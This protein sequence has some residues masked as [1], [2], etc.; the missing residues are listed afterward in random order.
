MMVENCELENYTLELDAL[1]NRQLSIY[2]YRNIQN[3]DELHKKL[4]NKE[5]PCCIVKANLILDPFQI[6]I[7]ANKAALNEKY[8]QMVARNLYTEI[9]YCLSIST[10][11]S[12]SLA[13]FGISKD[14]ANVLVIL[15]HDAQEKESM[16]KLVFDC[17][18][19]TRIPI[20]R[21]SDFSDISL[22][23]KTY[24]ICNEE[25]NIP[26]LLDSIVSRISE[27]I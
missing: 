14:T 3:I 13:A 10:N 16:E 22:I 17:I 19:G 12:Q 25:S 20:S 4:L 27:K 11:I 1:T 5:L 8:G 9:I 24:K 6:V 26:S 7:A 18:E 15:I 23:K 2:L 21:L